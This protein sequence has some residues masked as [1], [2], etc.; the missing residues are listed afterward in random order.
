MKN[1]GNNVVQVLLMQQKYCILTKNCLKDVT[2]AGLKGKKC[3]FPCTGC[4]KKY[5]HN[6][7]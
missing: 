5:A 3:I 6:V 2:F 7:Y 1:K 4:A